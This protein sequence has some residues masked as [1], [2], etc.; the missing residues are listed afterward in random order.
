MRFCEEADGT[1]DLAYSH[2][3]VELLCSSFL[4]TWTGEFWRLGIKFLISA[5]FHWVILRDIGFAIAPSYEFF[6][7]ARTR[8]GRA[9][10][11]I[12]LTLLRLVPSTSL[13]LYVELVYE[14]VSC[15]VFAVNEKHGLPVYN[16]I[17][18]FEQFPCF[19]VS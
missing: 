16:F 6:I 13:Q 2:H 17:V 5:P 14:F 1:R 18:D 19:V 4:T 3:P 12:M 10:A 11:A 7:F 15:H 9:N 8:C